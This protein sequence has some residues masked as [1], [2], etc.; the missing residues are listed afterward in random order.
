MGR[1]A[2][3]DCASGISGD[4]TLA[5][6]LDCGGDAEMLISRLQSLNL[7]EWSLAVTDVSDHGIGARHVA[8]SVPPEQGHGRHLHHI[9]EIIRGGDLPPTVQD[10]AIAVFRRLAEAEAE[11]HK[12]D[13]QS[14]HFHEV[15]AVD[16]IVDIVGV[17][18]LLDQLKVDRIAC[19]PLPM[20]HGFVECMHGVIP[21]PAPATVALTRG[22]PTYGVDVEGELVTPTGAALMT[23]LATEFGPQPAMHVER[24]GYGAGTRRYPDRPNVLRVMLGEADVRATEEVCV[25]ETNIDDLSPQLYDITQDRLFEAGA[26]DVFTAPVFMKKNRP[27]TLLTVLCS[28]QALRNIVAVLFAETTTLGVRIS[29][30]GRL[31]ME[32]ETVVLAT[33]YGDIR[34]KVACWDGEQAKAMPEYDDVK[35]AALRNGV[36]ARVIADAAMAAYRATAKGVNA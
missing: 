19:S 4:M 24:V 2:Y 26:L 31:C 22:F 11:I 27:A 28:E 29:R 36:P 21:L 33:E 34:I 17:C 5:A 30:C 9:E 10:R 23:T 1:T 8:V 18:L 20:G 32:R 35:A 6:L 12:V 13:V 3:F 14:L 15:G 25:V 16:A 7:G